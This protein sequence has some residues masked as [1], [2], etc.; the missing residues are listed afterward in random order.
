MNLGGSL[1]HLTVFFSF[2]LSKMWTEYMH[3]ELEKDGN[4]GYFPY[5]ILHF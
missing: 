4:T 3:T 5:D 1:S 2:L